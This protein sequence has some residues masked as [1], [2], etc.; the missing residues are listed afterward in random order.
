MDRWAAGPGRAPDGVRPGASGASFGATLDRTL[1][2]TAPTAGAAL[3]FSGH[4]A[5]RLAQADRRLNE[6]ELTEV[7]G[8]V[9]RAASKGSRDAL[10]LLSD[11][12]LVVNVK[13][14]TVIT[15]VPEERMRQNAFTQIDCVVLI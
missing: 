10:I 1:R 13:S 8:A 4:A 15:A 9:D 14:R 7:S 6:Q 3:R 12:A 2:R 5:D 11:L